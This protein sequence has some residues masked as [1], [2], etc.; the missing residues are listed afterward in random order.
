MELRKVLIA[1][2]HSLVRDGLRQL[3][4]S[5]CADVEVLETRN[6]RQTIEAVTRRTDI[7]LVL[8]DL[9]MPDMEGFTALEQLTAAPA[10]VPVVVVSASEDR[11]DMQRAL[12][13]GAMGYIPKSS[14]NAVLLGAIGLVLSGGIYLPPE[15]PRPGEPGAGTGPLCALTP[16][17]KQ[18]L[19]CMMRGL[20]NKGI[21]RELFLAEVTVKTH[22]SAIL[23]CLGVGSRTQVVLKARELGYRE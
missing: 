15:M 8:F 1:D 4:R 2:D 18:V 23:R 20:S 19:R 11:N 10:A 16:R 9:A 3:V 14:P 12:D 13:A 22:V 17:Q 6:C 7:D 5:L 21:A